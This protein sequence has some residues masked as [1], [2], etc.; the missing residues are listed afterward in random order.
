VQIERSATSISWIPSDSI[1]APLKLPFEQ[2]VMHYDPPP[3][4]TVTDLEGMR[5]RGHFRFANVMRAWIDVEDGKIHDYAY[6][7]HDLVPVVAPAESELER[8]LSEHVM[9][10]GKHP[11]VRELS[12]GE[13]LFRQAEQG[14]SMAVILDGTFEVRVNN[15]VVGQVGPPGAQSFWVARASGTDPAISWKVTATWSRAPPSASKAAA[16]TNSRASRVPGRSSRSPASP[17][18]SINQEARIQP[19]SSGPGRSSVASRAR[20]RWRTGFGGRSVLG[21]RKG[22]KYDA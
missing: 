10:D 20:R 16:A 2:G 12:T 15:Q 1:P 19:T 3:P 17:V 14:T 9:Q 4:L 8:V 13:F 7:G 11:R 21:G 18:P 6:G 5:R 22:V